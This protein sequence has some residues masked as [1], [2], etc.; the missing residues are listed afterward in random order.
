MGA[1]RRNAPSTPFETRVGVLLVSPRVSS[2]CAE[3]TYAAS[4]PRMVRSTDEAS[5]PGAAAVGARLHVVVGELVVSTTGHEGPAEPATPRRRRRSGHRMGS[6]AGGGGGTTSMGAGGVASTTGAGAAAWQARNV[7][8]RPSAGSCSPT[9]SPRPAIMMRVVSNPLRTQI[10]LHSLSAVLA[11]NEVR[12]AV[13]QRVVAGVHGDRASAELRLHPSRHAIERT[14]RDRARTKPSESSR[15]P[16]RRG[17]PAVAPPDWRRCRC[18]SPAP[19][20]LAPAPCPPRSRPSDPTTRP[21]V[22]IFMVPFSLM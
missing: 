7:T 9:S 22:L 14:D 2:V 16:P 13:P 20:P 6:G 3:P 5:I 10:V 1:F 12:L 11:Q 21:A 8:V 18:S 4:N 19:G 17:T 15:S